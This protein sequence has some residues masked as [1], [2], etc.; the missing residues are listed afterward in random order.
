MSKISKYFHEMD[1]LHKPRV[2]LLDDDPINLEIIGM[3]LEHLGLTDVQTAEN[4]AKALRL[5]RSAS[6]WPDIIF[7]DIYMPEMDG[8]EFLQKLKV[9][10][11]KGGVV[12]LSGVNIETLVLASQIASDLGLR[13]LGAV[14]KP[15]TTEALSH[16]LDRY[17]Q[18][19]N[20]G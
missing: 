4:G 9:L 5:L 6:V 8:I 14:E 3:H 2:L 10:D 11:F 13:L 1:L 17:S 20:P 15:I 18:P 19:P 16:F 12:L 7:L